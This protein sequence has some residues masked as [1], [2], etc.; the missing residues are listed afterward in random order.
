MTDEKLTELE[1]L[2]AEATRGPWEPTVSYVECTEP[3]NAPGYWCADVPAHAFPGPLSEHTPSMKAQADSNFIAAARDAVPALVAEVRRL[4]TLDD[5]RDLL[6]LETP[7]LDVVCEGDDGSA[8][9]LLAAL[10]LVHAQRAALAAVAAER[11]MHRAGCAASLDQ[12]DGLAAERDALRAEVERMRPV[13][14]TARRFAATRRAQLE[15]GSVNPLQVMIDVDA[16]T[17]AVDAY[18]KEQG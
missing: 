7:C 17:K 6:E 8:R 2:A 11:D 12:V 1:A 15:D 10:D 16:V 5:L 18:E 9:V 13:V 3:C 4:R 14:E